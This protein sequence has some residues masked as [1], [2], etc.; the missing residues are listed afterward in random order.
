MEGEAY[1]NGERVESSRILEV[2]DVVETATGAK[3]L[4]DFFDNSVT[5][6]RE[7]TN[8]EITEMDVN[9][10]NQME[11]NILLKLNAGQV[12]N[13][14]TKIVTQD[15]SFEVETYNTIAAVRGSAF[16]IKVDAETQATEVV[17]AQHAV[18]LTA[19]NEKSGEI[20][21]TTQVLEGYKTRIKK[22]L[23]SDRDHDGL[24]DDEEILFGTDPDNPDTD[25]DGFLDGYE[26]KN[27][28][29]PLG[30]GR[31]DEAMD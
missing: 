13:K 21:G 16:D 8:L 1:V 9:P 15:S 28:F 27:G 17:V 12:W 22:Q 31:L 26:V 3:A 24:F 7:K 18:D 25:G 10:E 29:N 5:R 23:R 20:L 2:G 11:T 6:L 19:V 30:E 14:V 4:I